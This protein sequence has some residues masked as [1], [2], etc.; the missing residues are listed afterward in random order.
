MV[1]I[2][3]AC[4]HFHPVFPLATKTRCRLP[5]CCRHLSNKSSRKQPRRLSCTD[6]PDPQGADLARDFSKFVNEKGAAP[7]THNRRPSHLLP[8][9][10][11][12][13]AQLD[14]LQLN[15]WP[16][17]AAGIQTAFLFSKPY[18]CE[19]MVT[20][21]PLPSHARSWHGKEEWFSLSEFTSML[22]SEDYRPL[23]NCESWQAT[24]PMVFPSTRIGTRAVQSVE[25]TSPSREGMKAAKRSHTF[26]FCL[27][28]VTQG[29]YKGCWMTV[30]LRLGDY[31]NV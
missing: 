17:R 3:C 12:V 8:P 18:G 30:G 4:C 2:T 23:I 13:A 9:T 19:D 24:S 20:G 11:A 6:K 25:V 31:A 22:Q 5:Q 7:P 21:P 27:E 28:H 14:A 29:P 16:D 15:D 10:A 1:H 26:T